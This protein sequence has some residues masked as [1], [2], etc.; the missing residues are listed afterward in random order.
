MTKNPFLEIDRLIVGDVYTSTAVMDTLTT[1]CDGFGSRF[2]GTTGEQEAVAFMQRIL[3][4]YGLQNVH[5][6][7][8]QYI[9]WRRGDVSLTVTEPVTRPIPAITLPHSPPADLTAPVIDLGDGAPADFDAR[10]DDIRGKIVLVTSANPPSAKRWVHRMEKYGRAVLAGAAGFIFVNHYPGYGPATGGIGPEAGGAGWIP[11][12]A[13]SR[14]E[15]AYVQRLIKQ[16]GTVQMRLQSSDV[17]EPMTSWNVIADLPGS[18]PDPQIVMLGS[19]YDGHDIS[20][21]ATDP[22]SGTV[23]V[24]EAARVLA[25]YAPQA[26]H[27]IRFALWGIEEIGLFGSTRYVETHADELD[28]IRFYLNMDMAGAIN[29]KDIVLNEWAELT[30]PF[31]AWSDEMA[32][33]YAVG[34]SLSAHSDHFPFMLAGVPTGAIGSV[35]PDLSGRGYAHTM[36]DTLDKAE[37]R[38]L[39]EAAV[40]A[41]RLAL[42]MARAETWP[43]SRRAP[44]RVREKMQTDA[45]FVEERALFDRVNAF[46]AEKR[47]AGD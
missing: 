14:E 1:L 8:V 16:H 29:P 40:L 44:A 43:A 23:A 3:T 2:G 5:A 33:P 47:A 15:G 7:P 11:A 17:V 38:S 20:Q 25:A 27:T 4:E 31:Q 45:G 9:G 12:V 28:R 34:Q 22:A 37:L 32:L 39:R 10:A 13:L 26:P 24:L 6:E 21:G 30:R 18:A 41:A 19:H 46:Y 42:R 36:Y 35:R